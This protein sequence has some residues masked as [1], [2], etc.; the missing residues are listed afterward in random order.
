MGLTPLQ[1]MVFLAV[2]VPVLIYTVW[3]DLSRMKIY[4][5]TVL[6]M[7]AVFVLVGPLVLPVDDYL[8]RYASFAIVLAFGFVLT[9]AGGVGGGDSKFAA[10]AAPFVAPEDIRLVVVL[11][12]AASLAAVATHRIAR[13]IPAIRRQAP[14]WHSWSEARD[15]PLGFALATTLILYFLSPLILLIA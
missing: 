15:F 4:N 11:L 14:D 12:C 13:A 3:T 2:T 9:I 10:A 5:R 8:N 7:F 1:G 6:L